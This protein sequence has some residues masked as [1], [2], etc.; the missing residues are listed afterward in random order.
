MKSD[1]TPVSYPA[2]SVS[3]AILPARFER[4]LFL[5]YKGTGS[6]AKPPAGSLR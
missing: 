6:A 3:E 1:P 2:A 4:I 5:K